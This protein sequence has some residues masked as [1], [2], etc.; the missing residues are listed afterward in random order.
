MDFCK[1]EAID[2]GNNMSDFKG[3]IF[4]CQIETSNFTRPHAVVFSRQNLGNGG[5][6]LQELSMTEER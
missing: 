4:G 3:F 5:S 2:K 1:K 6:G